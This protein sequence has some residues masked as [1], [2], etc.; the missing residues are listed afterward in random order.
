MHNPYIFSYGYNPGYDPKAIDRWA[1]YKPNDTSDT[2]NNNSHF[3]Y[4]MQHKSKADLY[5][6]A[7]LL[8]A[9]HLPTGASMKIDYE[10]DDYA[11]VQDKRAMQMFQLKGIT[12]FNKTGTDNLEGKNSFV[13]ELNKPLAAKDPSLYE[14][15]RGI[16]ELYFNCKVNIKNNSTDYES[17]KGFIAIDPTI[18]LDDIISL[19]G[20][21]NSEGKFSYAKINYSLVSINDDNSSGDMVNPVSKA[22]WELYAYFYRVIPVT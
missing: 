2:A 6:A 5:S 11:Y 17:I 7:W 14:Y 1:N 16:N 13:F 12:G 3:P 18:H 21:R 20:E 4:T 22:S 8:D 15:V 19:T 9:I 10:A